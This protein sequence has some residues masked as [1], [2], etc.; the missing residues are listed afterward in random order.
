MSRDVALLDWHQ[1][2]FVAKG[3]LMGVRMVKSDGLQSCSQPSDRSGEWRTTMTRLGHYRPGSLL[4]HS[5]VH[6]LTAYKP[7]LLPI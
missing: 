5:I 1:T 7:E 3:G 6:L 4:L 2:P